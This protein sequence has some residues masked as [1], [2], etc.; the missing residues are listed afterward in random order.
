MK[1]LANYILEEIRL[2]TFYR[3]KRLINE[4]VETITKPQALAIMSQ[5]KLEFFVV[6]NKKNGNERVMK[7]VGSS[8]PTYKRYLR[9][10]RLPY[11]AVEKGVMPVFDLGK[12]QYRMVNR[13][14]IK[15]LKIGNKIYDVR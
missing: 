2:E 13:L 12:N 6:Y 9:G 7:A 4:Q 15:S 11:D 10:G 3:Y 1:P 5:T 8:N 14:T